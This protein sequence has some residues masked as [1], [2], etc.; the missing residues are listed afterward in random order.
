MLRT[1]A[2]FETG[3]YVRL[4]PLRGRLVF[5]A[6]PRRGDLPYMLEIERPIRL[7]PEKPVQIIIYVDGTL[8]EVY[9]DNQVAMSARIYDHLD[10][11]WGFFVSE[12][13]VA[14]SDVRLSTPI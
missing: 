3:Y 6:W 10:G 14:F 2:D 13:E 9:V 4:E 7:D 5:D 11:N 1:S 12:G 8:C